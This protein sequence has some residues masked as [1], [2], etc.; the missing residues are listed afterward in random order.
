MFSYIILQFYIF[1]ILLILCLN[2][3]NFVLKGVSHLH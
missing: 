1:S 2:F 3:I